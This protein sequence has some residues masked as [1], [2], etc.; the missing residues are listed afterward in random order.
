MFD[1][2][3]NNFLNLNSIKFSILDKQVFNRYVKI[4][5]YPFI[6]SRI[7]WSKLKIHISKPFHELEK[8]IDE[9]FNIILELNK[10]QSDIILIGN[11]FKDGYNIEFSKEN[12]ELILN[13]LLDYPGENYLFELEQQWCICIY[14]VLDFGL[15]EL[16]LSLEDK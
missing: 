9:T 2:E 4:E 8:F 5:N 7:S 14:D 1:D 12:L 10:N 15:S 6:G 11:D 16:K 3:L 13:F